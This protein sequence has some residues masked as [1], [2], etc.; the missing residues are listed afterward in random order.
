M[1]LFQKIVPCTNLH[2][3]LS[4]RPLLFL[5]LSS[6]PSETLLVPSGP[7]H[8]IIW[9]HLLVMGPS[10]FALP[11]ERKGLSKVAYVRWILKEER[12]E[13]ET[14]EEME[15]MMREMKSEQRENED[16][17]DWFKRLEKWQKLREES[18]TEELEN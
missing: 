10:S 2:H 16:E 8:L 17:K 3:L 13:S 12:G 5:A 11:N 6:L 15:E 9:H 7:S 18:R 14:L 4:S 1:Q